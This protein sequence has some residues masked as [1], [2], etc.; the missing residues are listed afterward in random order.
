MVFNLFKYKNSKASANGNIR[1]L[2]KK[3]KDTGS[4][5]NNSRVCIETSAGISSIKNDD[6]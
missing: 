5:E 2:D 1:K 3:F 4:I 6:N